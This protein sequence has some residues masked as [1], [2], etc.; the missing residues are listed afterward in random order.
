MTIVIQV[1]ASYVL[2]EYLDYKKWQIFEKAKSEMKVYDPNELS[3]E[4][5]FELIYCQGKVT[6]HDELEDEEFKVSCKDS[7]KLRR[8][9]EMYQIEEY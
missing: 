3:E 6:I 9:V 4:Q 7:Y 1:V 8:V 5:N 2:I